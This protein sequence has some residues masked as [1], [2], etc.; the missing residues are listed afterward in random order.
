MYSSQI[1]SP[2]EAD[3]HKSRSFADDHHPEH[4][5]RTEGDQAAACHEH[6]PH[7][8]ALLCREIH[9]RSGVDAKI[10]EQPR[11]D[12]DDIYQRRGSVNR[13][14]RVHEIGQRPV[15]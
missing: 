9:G 3:N 2:D 13:A 10:A 8:T 1:G 15:G 6:K 4:D 12:A 7:D 11:G 14:P 5:R